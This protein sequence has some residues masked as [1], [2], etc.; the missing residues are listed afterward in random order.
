M[1]K[2]TERQRETLE[3]LLRSDDDLSDQDVQVI[4]KAPHSRAGASEWIS[5]LIEKQQEKRA[6]QRVKPP[7]GQPEVAEGRY[8]LEIDGKLRFFRVDVPGDGKWEGWRFVKEQ[9]GENL[10]PVRKE[11]GAKI[12]Q[13]I[14]ADAEAGPR[15]GQELGF[16]F[17]CGRELTD[18]TSRALGVGPVCRAG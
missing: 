15:Y 18:E 11:A 16:C 6:R 4:L 1:A 9:A 14:H 8:A 12:L 13:L 3:K 10:F 5:R 17:V 7:A 2:M